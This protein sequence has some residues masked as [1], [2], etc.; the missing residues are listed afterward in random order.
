VQVLPRREAAR[1]GRLGQE[2][3]ALG[4]GKLEASGGGITQLAFSP[5]GQLV[6]AISAVDSRVLLFNVTTGLER[7]TLRGHS[8]PLRQFTLSREGDRLATA[9]DDGGVRIWDLRSRTSRPLQGHT[10]KVTGLAFSPDG[11]ELTTVGEDQTIRFWPDSLPNDEAELR[12]WI[13]TATP[14]TLDMY[15]EPRAPLLE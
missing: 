15:V 12:T 9:G 6:A 3:P 10:G 14:D 1:H 2:H 8:S 13:Q 5:D 4:R 11:R 7:A